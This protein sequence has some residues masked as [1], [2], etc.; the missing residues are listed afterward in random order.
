[1]ARLKREPEA[2]G[3]EPVNTKILIQI[4]DERDTRWLIGPQTLLPQIEMDARQRV[5]NATAGRV[6]YLLVTIEEKPAH[7]TPKPAATAP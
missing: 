2:R 6:P 5:V 7:E 4:I 1:M 3:L